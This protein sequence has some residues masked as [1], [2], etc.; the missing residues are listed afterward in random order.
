MTS[1]IPVSEELLRN[2]FHLAEQRLHGENNHTIT[3]KITAEAAN[4]SWE[5]TLD[6]IFASAFGDVFPKCS[7][8]RDRP[9]FN[10]LDICMVHEDAIVTAIESKGMVANSHSSDGHRNSLDLHGIRTKLYPDKRNWNK[11][12]EKHNCVQTDIVEISGKIPTGMKGAHFE[13]FIPVIYELYRE[14]GT[15]ADW[16]SEK[17][18]RVTLPK[19]KELRGDMRDDLTQWFQREDPTIRLIHAAESIELR[20]ANKLWLKQ[21]QWKFLQFTSL[22]AYVSFYAFARFVE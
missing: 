13:L 18:P 5:K 9:E 17:K 15:K 3:K 14:G 2:A 22:E 20:D 10:K 16:H 19:F 4:V 7:V 21:A 12:T 11:K 6:V 1:P 8:Y